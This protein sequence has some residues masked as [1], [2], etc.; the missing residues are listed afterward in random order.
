MLLDDLEGE[1]DTNLATTS[2]QLM[3]MY[4]ERHLASFTE[5]LSARREWLIRHQ[6]TVTKTIS[7]KPDSHRHDAR[8]DVR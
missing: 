7:M 8:V 4:T 1:L 5:E 6:P 2:R 3:T